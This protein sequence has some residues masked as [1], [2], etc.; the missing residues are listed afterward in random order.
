MRSGRRRAMNPPGMTRLRMLVGLLVL[1]GGIYLGAMFIPPYWAYVSMLDPVKEAAMA[2]AMRGGNEE[3]IRT[4]LMAKARDLGFELAE[5]NVEFVR[6]GNFV[7]IRVAW[8][9]S[10]D[11]PRYRHTLRF[12]VE[13][14]APAP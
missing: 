3:R 1:V 13:S 4:N 8:E 10:V 7:V 5:E 6:D 2:A 11:L 12:H 14:Q 9:V